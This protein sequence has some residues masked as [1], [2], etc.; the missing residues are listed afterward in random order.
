[1]LLKSGFI[2]ADNRRRLVGQRFSCNF[3]SPVLG[4]FRERMEAGRG[5][6]I[7]YIAELPEDRLIIETAFAPPTVLGMMI[8]QLGQ[9]FERKAMDFD[10]YGVCFPTL[11]S[12]AYGRIDYP[13]FPPAAAPQIRFALDGSD[14]DRLVRGLSLCAEALRLAGA[15]EVFDSRYDGSTVRMTGDAGTDRARLEAYYRDTGPQTFVKV[16]SAHLQGGNVIHRDP[17]LGVVDGDLK[18][19]GVENLWIFDS[20]VFPAPITLNIQ[21]ATL[22]LARYAALRMPLG[23]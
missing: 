7:G 1:L 6:Q 9:E 12:D 8:S 21:Y 13:G 14:W 22:A 3:A 15:E 16:Q 2:S 5:M 11:S 17:T 18:V 4:R 23:G 20:S 19:H 10:H